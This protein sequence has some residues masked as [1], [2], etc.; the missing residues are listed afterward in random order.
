M[1]KQLNDY[2]DWLVDIEV[3]ERRLRKINWRERGRERFKALARCGG[4]GRVFKNERGAG[5]H[6]RWC[7]G[8]GGG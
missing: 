2:M 8:Q 3:E 6:R 1:W 5:S 7:P 4:C